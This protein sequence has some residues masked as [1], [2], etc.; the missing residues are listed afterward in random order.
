MDD[1]PLNGRKAIAELYDLKSNITY[2][3]KAYNL[4]Q[5]YSDMVI[6]FKRYNVK[7]TDTMY[8]DMV[9]HI[10]N[11]DIGYTGVYDNDIMVT[12]ISRLYPMMQEMDVSET[13]SNIIRLFRYDLELYDIHFLDGI[14]AT[15][16][17]TVYDDITLYKDVRDSDDNNI[18]LI[19]NIIEMGR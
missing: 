5:G 14:E 3:F 10:L 9:D 8:T 17:Y 4:E 19:V 2:A 12:D 13:I 7:F 6:L 16:E 11:N 15:G 18:N 1:I